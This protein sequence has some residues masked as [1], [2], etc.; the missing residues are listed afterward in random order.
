MIEILSFILSSLL[1]LWSRVSYMAYHK[2]G[3][4]TERPGQVVNSPASNSGVPGFK[5]LPGDQQS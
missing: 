4:C 3:C 2:T 1:P 5:S